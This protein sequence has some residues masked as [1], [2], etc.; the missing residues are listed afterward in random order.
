MAPQKAAFLSAHFTAIAHATEDI[1]KVEQGVKFLIDLVSTTSVSLT[2]RYL[3]GHHG[4][5]ITAISA[6]LSAKELSSD[7]L[8]L[9]SQ[10]LPE[11]DRRFLSGDMRSCIDEESNLY[12][13]FDKQEALLG[14]VKLH[15]GDPIRLKLKFASTYDAETMV[16][17]CRESG[18]IL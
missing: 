16:N 12:L 14:N 7:P 11:S 18:L 3:K 10:K 4:N 17:V 15:Q 5:V 2:R 1:E 9:V 6:K 13:R 8:N